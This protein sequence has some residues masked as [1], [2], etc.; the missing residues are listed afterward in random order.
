MPRARR[1]DAPG[2]VHHVWARGLDKHPILE[3]DASRQDLF[4]RCDRILPASGMTC[5]AATLMSNHLHL[6]VR[7]GPVPLSTVMRRLHTGFALRFNRR[8]QRCGYLFQSRFGSRIARNDADVCTMIAYVLRNPLTAGVVT[9][10]AALERYHW[11]SYGAVTGRRPPH[12]FESV[13]ATL[14]AFGD[15]REVALARLAEWILQ[16]PELRSDPP[17]V[18]DVIR[19]VCRERGLA[20]ADVRAGRRTAAAVEARAH[21]CRRAVFELGLRATDVARA[22]E[23]TRGAVSQ[24]LRRPPPRN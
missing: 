3:D 13:S 4:D 10:L 19:S 23:L 22:L 18:E 11:S 7:T 16:E 14:A 15:V 20:E 24:A 17:S 21:I 8:N 6:V 5:L 1:E 9:G 2:I 12:A